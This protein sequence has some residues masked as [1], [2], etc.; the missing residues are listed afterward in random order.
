MFGDIV[1]SFASPA[2]N[3]F[4]IVFNGRNLMIACGGDGRIHEVDRETG[5]S[6]R[7]FPYLFT[8]NGL[9]LMENLL[10]QTNAANNAIYV[11]DL[12]GN[13]VYTLP[14]VP[15]FTFGLT[16]MGGG[17]IIQ[18]AY[19]DVSLRNS[20]LLFRERGSS[21]AEVR[22]V[23]TGLYLAGICF[24]GKDIYGAD[25]NLNRLYKISID[26]DVIASAVHPARPVGVAFDGKSLWVTND[27]TDLIYCVS[28]N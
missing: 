5:L 13:L 24:D 27:T 26:G 16:W 21:W 4:G 7:S 1:R 3:P 19:N 12:L 20:Y 10:L 11:T 15:Q 17:M 18:T 2:L 14:V 8:Q 6:I 28:V 9:G 25:Y 23:D 22:R